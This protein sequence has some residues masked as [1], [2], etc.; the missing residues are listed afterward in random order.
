MKR[1]FVSMLTL[2]AVLAAGLSTLQAAGDARAKG[3]RGG[4][5]LEGTDPVAEFRLED[6]HSATVAFYGAALQPVAA[7]GQSVTLIATTA[8]GRQTIEF[9]SQG[10][11]L[12]SATKL[13]DGDGYDLA[14]QL[15]STPDAKPRIF[16]FKLLTHICDGC[17][18]KEYACVC[19]E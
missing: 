10:D 9:T 7:G 11:I 5:L 14:L 1:K 17:K 2:M 12:A 15:R 8:A 3:P 13:P 18:L 4:R 16:R 6:D 19:D